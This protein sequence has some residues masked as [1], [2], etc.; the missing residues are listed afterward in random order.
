MELCN[1]IAALTRAFDMELDQKYDPA[2]R[3]PSIKHA[4]I[5]SRAYVPVVCTPRVCPWVFNM[6]SWAF[7]FCCCSVFRALIGAE[8]TSLKNQRFIYSR[9]HFPN[10]SLLKNKV[11]APSLLS[12]CMSIVTMVTKCGGAAARARSFGLEK[13]V[14]EEP[15]SLRLWN[16]L[17]VM[18][19][20]TSV[21]NHPKRK[22]I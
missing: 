3:L 21:F 22:K 7:N 16:V 15:C 11:Y 18:L 12:R 13:L 17:K 14:G 1:V 20:C 10:L 2:S 9:L 8:G 4:V 6:A 19:F 5:S